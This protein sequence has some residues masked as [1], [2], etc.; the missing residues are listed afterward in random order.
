MDTLIG[1]IGGLM[2]VVAILVGLP[3]LIVI[4]LEVVMCFK[5]YYLFCFKYVEGKGWGR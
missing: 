5:R 2:M 1:F 4:I 3:W